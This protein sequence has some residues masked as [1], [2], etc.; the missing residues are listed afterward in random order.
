MQ[1]L[2]PSS[3]YGVLVVVQVRLRSVFWICDKVLLLWCKSIN[4]HCQSTQEQKNNLRLHHRRLDLRTK[5][6][7]VRIKDES[8]RTEAEAKVG[9]LMMN[10]QKETLS[11]T[12]VLSS[13][14]IPSFIVSINEH[15]TWLP[16]QLSLLHNHHHHPPSFLPASPTSS[17]HKPS[18]KIVHIAHSSPARSLRIP[19]T[20]SKRLVLALGLKL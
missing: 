8:E 10:K 13:H 17:L 9:G 7:R 6:I 1:Y 4:A 16:L 14:L 3:G 11:L 12:R 18:T 5:R 20:T 15:L 19:L 2:T